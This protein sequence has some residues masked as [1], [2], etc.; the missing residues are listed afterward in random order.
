MSAKQK[1]VD[2]SKALLETLKLNFVSK[3]VKQ[4]R[5]KVCGGCEFK[6]SAG[7]ADRCTKCDCFLDWKTAL[8]KQ[9]CPDK[10]WLKEL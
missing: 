8:K 7:I 9:E 5:L 4:I 2:V 6:G 10:K 3:E 1:V